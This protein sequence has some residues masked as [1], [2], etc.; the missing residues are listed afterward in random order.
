M[1]TNTTTVS[2]TTSTTIHATGQAPFFSRSAAYVRSMVEHPYITGVCI[3]VGGCC[4]VLAAR[5]ALERLILRCNF[6][7]FWHENVMVDTLTNEQKKEITQELI[8]TIYYG[9]E[10]GVNAD[11]SFLYVH[12]FVQEV[13][14]ELTRL[15]YLLKLNNFLQRT[16]LIALIPRGTFCDEDLR[17]HLKHVTALRTLFIDWM[18]DDTTVVARE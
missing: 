9:N 3:L 7:S 8:R 11:D 13:H 4:A 12:A 6:W 10:K 18:Y 2:T 17:R 1:P 5:Y 14:A 15:N 16:K